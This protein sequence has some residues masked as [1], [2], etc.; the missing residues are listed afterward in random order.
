MTKHYD[1]I[2]V[3]LG[4]MGSAA[5][6]HLAKRGLNA[7]G[8][9]RY[10]DSARDGVVTWF[11]AASSGWRITK[12]CPMC[13]CCAGLMSFGLNWSANS[14]SSSSIK[15]AASTWVRPESDVFSGSLN[16]CLDNDLE[17][18]VLD[19]NQLRA[20]FPG[21]QMPAE[22]MALYQPQGGLL[23]PERCVV[24]HAQ[25]AASTWRGDSQR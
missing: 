8:I 16:S 6:Y 14:A 1:V 3:G 15:P 25:L 9:E 19:S 24:A 5:L 22:T 12:I 23:L 20:R 21:Y 18:E 13:R 4:G 7:L 11:D 2:V 10:D 17:F